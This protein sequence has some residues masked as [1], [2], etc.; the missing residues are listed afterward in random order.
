M[1]PQECR[2]RDL[3]ESMRRAPGASA[4]RS[5]IFALLTFEHMLQ[6]RLCDVLEAIADAL[7][8][9]VDHSAAEA[10]ALFLR[11]HYPAHFAAEDDVLYPAVAQGEP[12]GSALASAVDQARAEHEVDLEAAR[13]LADSLD[14]LVGGERVNTEAIGYMLRGFFE[15]QRRHIS[16]EERVLFPLA[17]QKIDRDMSAAVA[18]ELFKR[19]LSGSVVPFRVV[20]G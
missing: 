4:Q 10:A 16:W 13:E 12:K 15:S 2:L 9:A 6:E 3:T 11:T 8:G 19:R 1:S 14:D 5:D 17:R 7:P 18:A 20:S